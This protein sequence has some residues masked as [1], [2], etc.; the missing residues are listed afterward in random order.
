MKSR[1]LAKLIGWK[2]SVARP[3]GRTIKGK[4]SLSEV[5]CRDQ[6]PGGNAA[7]TPCR[8]QLWSVFR[9]QEQGQSLT[10]PVCILLANLKTQSQGLVVTQAL[11]PGL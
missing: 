2:Q 8:L 9:S 3:L 4:E 5:T 10:P 11:V 6:T 1:N 7:D